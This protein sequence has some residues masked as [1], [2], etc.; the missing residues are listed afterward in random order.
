MAELFQSTASNSADPA[1]QRLGITVLAA[2][3]SH[4]DAAR[5]LA[6]PMGLR[7][8]IVENPPHY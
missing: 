7:V 4:F 3:R 2:V 6:E 1:L 8:D 5:R